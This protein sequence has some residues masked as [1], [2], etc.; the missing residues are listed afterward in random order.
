[1]VVK[2]VCMEIWKL[3]DRLRYVQIS[4]TFVPP[5]LILYFAYIP[6]A[7]RTKIPCSYRFGRSPLGSTRKP[8]R[9]YS[10]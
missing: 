3:E 4:F 2:I 7:N 5:G 10:L 1:M 6:Q 8:N 9:K